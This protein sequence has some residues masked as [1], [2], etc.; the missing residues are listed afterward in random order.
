MKLDA[1]GIIAGSG[2]YPVLL[3]EAARAQ[4]VPRLAAVGFPGETTP[5]VAKLVD[6]YAELRVGQ[7]GALCRYFQEQKIAHAIM[8]VIAQADLVLIPARPSPHDLRACRELS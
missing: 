5:E 1:L 6:H 3:A 8:A 4:G 2:R 7:L